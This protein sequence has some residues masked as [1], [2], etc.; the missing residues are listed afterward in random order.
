[1]KIDWTL[2]NNLGV[3]IMLLLL[4]FGLFVLTGYVS[5]YN[6]EYCK[7]YGIGDTINTQYSFINGAI[8]VIG[9]IVGILAVIKIVQTVISTM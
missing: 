3:C 2:L 8:S 9:T 5:N 1:M 7:K 4:T 6:R